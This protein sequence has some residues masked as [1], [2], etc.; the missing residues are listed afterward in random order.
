MLMLPCPVN[1]TQLGKMCA[2]SRDDFDFESQLK[3][4][5]K[6]RNFEVFYFREVGE[7]VDILH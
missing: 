3:M 5:T 4:L 2:S 1:V 7:G 6:T